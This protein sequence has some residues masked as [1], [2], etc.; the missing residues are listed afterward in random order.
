M[1]FNLLF[2]VMKVQELSHALKIWIRSTSVFQWLPNDYYMTTKATW[3][4]NIYMWAVSCAKQNDYMTSFCFF[5]ITLISFFR[6][7]T[8]W[9]MAFFCPTYSIVE[10]SPKPT[11]SRQWA[12]CKVRSNILLKQGRIHGYLSRV[13]LSRGSDESL[14]ASKQRNT[15]SKIRW[16]R[17]TDGHSVL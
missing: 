12:G 14:Q 4:L 7:E 10:L 5:S 2:G 6:P 11:L 16:H 8:E 1:R 13:R 3:L 17:R 15:R 9:V